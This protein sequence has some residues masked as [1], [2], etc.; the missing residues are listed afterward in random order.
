VVIWL[1]G[2][3]HALDTQT[4]TLISAS[5]QRIVRKFR[6]SLAL[7]EYLKVSQKLAKLEAKR[8]EVLNF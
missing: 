4:T 3:Q 5:Q 2:I 1:D 7:I 8:K 6:L